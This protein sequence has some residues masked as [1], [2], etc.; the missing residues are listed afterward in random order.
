MS[1]LLVLA[2]LPGFA[3]VELKLALESPTNF[4]AQRRVPVLLYGK[5]RLGK[6]HQH[7]EV[8]I[9]TQDLPVTFNLICNEG[10]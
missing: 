7:N 8:E 3:L 10:V 9:G 6:P 4:N 1:Q 5:R 2:L